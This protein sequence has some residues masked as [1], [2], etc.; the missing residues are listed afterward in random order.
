MGRKARNGV[1]TEAG[2]FCLFLAR[3]FSCCFPPIRTPG[4]DYEKNVTL[5]LREYFINYFSLGVSCEK[6]LF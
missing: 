1:R 5:G 2:A 4:T 3:R 6:S